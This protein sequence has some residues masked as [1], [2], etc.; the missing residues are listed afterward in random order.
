MLL[1][2]EDIVVAIVGDEGSVVDGVIPLVASTAVVRVVAD[3][4]W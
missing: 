3:H 1:D 2:G 4:T